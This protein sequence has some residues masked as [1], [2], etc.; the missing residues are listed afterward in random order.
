MPTDFASPVLLYDGVCGL[1][2]RTV[3]FTLKRD[4]R[5]QLRFASLQSD[6]ASAV[7]R[8]YG[9][10]AR[11]LDSVYLV[12][13]CGSPN[14]RLLSRSDAIIA[15]LRLLRG[16]WPLIAAIAGLVPRPLRD[17][18]YGVIARNRYRIFGKN[19]ICFPPPA[20]SQDRFLDQ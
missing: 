11:D 14:E 16:A 17:W 15:M 8:R 3:Q 10:D 19:E 4:V 20:D 5:R 9:R 13:D 18:M 7:L 2:N 6:F 12:E 1:C